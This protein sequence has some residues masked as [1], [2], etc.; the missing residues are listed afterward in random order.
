MRSASEGPD[1]A[2][3]LFAQGI[4]LNK[5]SSTIDF[6]PGRHDP[7]AQ[8]GHSDAFYPGVVIEVAC[9][10][11]EMDFAELAEEY[12]LESAG[13]IRAVVC[14]KIPYAQDGV[15]T[16]SVWRPKIVLD[17]AGVETLIASETTCIQVI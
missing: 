3:A 17:S 15:P 7:D 12:I 4:F 5:G 14:V 8:F 11:S 13:D 16:L 6:R 9:P 2:A 10:Q 1:T